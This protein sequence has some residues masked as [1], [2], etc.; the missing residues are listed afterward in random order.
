MSGGPTVDGNGDV[1]G[2]NSFGPTETTELFN[3]VTSSA[4]LRELMTQNGVAGGLT[5]TDHAYRA[6]LDAYFAG[7]YSEAVE[8]F[9]TVLA[10]APGHEV[11]AEYRTRAL[12]QRAQQGWPVSRWVLFTIGGAVLALLGA[13]TLVAVRRRVATRPVAPAPF[14]VPA[15]RASQPVPAAP[16]FRRPAPPAPAPPR[17]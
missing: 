3:Y 14:D 6:G 1:V 2:I 12:Q 5:P 13:G 7:D 17:W 11:A 4:N 9:D 10:A 16:L 8:Q 15:P